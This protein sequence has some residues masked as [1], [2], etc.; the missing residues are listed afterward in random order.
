MRLS[1]E[2]SSLLFFSLLFLCGGLTY[3]LQSLGGDARASESIV[4]MLIVLR[5]EQ[6]EDYSLNKPSPRSISKILAS[7]TH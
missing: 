1:E 4:R 7:Y 6:R 5:T 3:R 2:V